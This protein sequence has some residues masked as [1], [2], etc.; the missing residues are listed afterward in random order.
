MLP[1]VKIAREGFEGEQK[2]QHNLWIS[3]TDCSLVTDDLVRYMD[4]ASKTDAFLVED[5]IWAEDF[6][7]N[8]EIFNQETD[9]QQEAHI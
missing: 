2:T 4:A 7:P 9:S 6:A 1:S 5:P 3:H 8:G